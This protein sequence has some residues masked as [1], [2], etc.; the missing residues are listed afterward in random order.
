MKRSLLLTLFPAVMAIGCG[1]AVDER[2]QPGVGDGD[3][4]GDGDGAS[5]VNR[6]PGNVGDGDSPSPGDGDWSVGDG[7]TP[8]R[9]TPGH[10]GVGVG[11]ST[12]SPLVGCE[13][14]YGYTASDY[15]EAQFTCENGWTYVYCDSWDGET[16]CGCDSSR[17][18]M[19]VQPAGALNDSTC[20]DVARLC[21]N[22]ET[23]LAIPLTCEPFYSE[24][25]P[26]YCS[27]GAECRREV[28]LSDGTAVTTT[29]WRETWCGN[30]ENAWF[31]EC[32]GNSNYYNYG[33]VVRVEFGGMQDSRTLC[34]EFLDVCSRDAFEPTGATDC[35][36]RS[37]WSDRAS[38]QVELECS[39]PAN[40]AGHA[41]QVYEYRAASCT[42]QGGDLWGC[43][44][45]SES[46]TVQSGSSWDACGAAADICGRF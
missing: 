23:V 36:P 24:T 28:P 12:G 11:G 13:E 43:W 15:C 20:R 41:G 1:I 38:C 25:Q 14:D 34:T 22:P 3:G 17:I 46:F 29:E 31:C 21:Q 45:G 30:Y 18:Y 35:A 19:H 9:P 16:K 33:N 27:A 26:A 40:V 42:P 8:G 10:P 5:N 7:D 2:T 37:Q 4:D 6:P 39:F 32:Y 44:C